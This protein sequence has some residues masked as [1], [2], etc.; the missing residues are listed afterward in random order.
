MGL[1]R[2]YWSHWPFWL[3]APQPGCQAVVGFPSRAA[4]APAWRS[5]GIRPL[6]KATIPVPPDPDG[7]TSRSISSSGTS[8]EMPARPERVKAGAVGRVKAREIAVSGSERGG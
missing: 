5:P 1:G 2:S 3:G 4:A 8:A 6:E 7:P